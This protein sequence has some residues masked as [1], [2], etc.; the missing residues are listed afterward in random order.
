M[1]RA[2]RKVS[3]VLVLGFFK[4]LAM[5]ASVEASLFFCEFATDSFPLFSIIKRKRTV[6]DGSTGEKAVQKATGKRGP[7]PIRTEGEEGVA[8][9]AQ[10]ADSHVP[11]VGTEPFSM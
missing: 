11:Y 2:C 4:K 3:L 6:P 9:C 10:P 1:E 7:S 5:G 8:S